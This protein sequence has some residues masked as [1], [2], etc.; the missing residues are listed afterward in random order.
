MRRLPGR[1]CHSGWSPPGA[2]IAVALPDSMDDDA[3]AQVVD[4]D[5]VI[6][7]A[8]SARAALDVTARPPT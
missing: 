5:L 8:V 4:M 3:L 7:D 6:R 2:I 1:S